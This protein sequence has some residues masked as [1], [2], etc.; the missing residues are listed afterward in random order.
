[1]GN[2]TVY[3]PYEVEKFFREL[4]LV[5]QQKL[6]QQFIELVRVHAKKKN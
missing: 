2:I 3:F 6:R 4:P 1:M 5:E